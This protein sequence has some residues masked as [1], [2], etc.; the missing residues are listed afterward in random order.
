MHLDVAGGMG[1]IVFVSHDASQGIGMYLDPAFPVK[2]FAPGSSARSASYRWNGRE[3]SV[4]VDDGGGPQ[5]DHEQECSTSAW[6]LQRADPEAGETERAMHH[7]DRDSLS[8]GHLV[9]LVEDPP[10]EQRAMA[11]PCQGHPDYAPW[12]E[13]CIMGETRES[14]HRL[15]HADLITR[16]PDIIAHYAFLT[17][18]EGNATCLS[19][20]V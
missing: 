6:R 12:C 3:A 2:G 11:P 5:P 15:A 7:R 13:A 19:C 8:D 20:D 4:N 16:A 9:A 17:I 14:Q 1:P 18:C 10:L